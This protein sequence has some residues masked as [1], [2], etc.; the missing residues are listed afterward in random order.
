MADQNLISREDCILVVIDAQ[1]RLMPAISGRE[2][3]VANIAT[4]VRF[5]GIC[6]I[7]VVFTEQRKLGPTVPEVKGVTQGFAAVEKVHF[8]CFL[9]GEFRD[10]VERLGRKTLVIAGAEAHI[11]VAQTA[12]GAPPHLGVHI[13]ADAVSSRSPDN[14][15]IAIERMREAGAVITSTE[16]FIYEMLR[17]AGTDEFKAVLPLVK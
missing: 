14:R 3:V 11:C 12:I 4:L 16:M 1:E 10:E 15:S 2:G 5:C 6:G 13:V 17:E 9:N 7:P 8:N